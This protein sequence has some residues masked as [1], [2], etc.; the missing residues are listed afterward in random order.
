MTELGY[1]DDIYKLAMLSHR[2]REE[3]LERLYVL[4]GHKQKLTEFFRIIDQ[5]SNGCAFMIF[6]YIRKAL[7]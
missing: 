2:Q 5:V 3:M 6:S 1:G 7:L 4:P